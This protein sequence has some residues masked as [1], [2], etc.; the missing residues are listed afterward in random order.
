METTNV[1][2]RT[3]SLSRR[4]LITRG[5]VAGGL[6]WAAPAITSIGRA[7]GQVAGTPKPC[8][9]TFCATVDPPVGATLYFD[10]KGRSSDD[11]NCLCLCAGVDSACSHPDDP[12]AV[13]VICEPRAT[14]C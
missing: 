13:N 6:V 11:C 9:C 10:C 12:C 4:T 2:D 7:H 1:G 3:S 14:P 8:D 5:I